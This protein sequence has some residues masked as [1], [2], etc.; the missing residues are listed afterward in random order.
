MVNKVGQRYFPSTGSTWASRGRSTKTIGSFVNLVVGVD[1]PQ[2]KYDPGTRNVGIR[3]EWV[4]NLTTWNGDY[5]LHSGEEIYGLDITGSIYTNG[6]LAVPP[7]VH[8][9]RI[10]GNAASANLPTP[11]IACGSSFNLRG[12]VF[13]WCDFDATGH[14]DP[15]LDGLSG[16]NFTVRH[17]EISRGVDGVHLTQGNVTVDRCRIYYGHYFA[18]WNDV[19][20]AVRTTSFTDYGGKT[21]NPPFPSQ[22]SGD[23]HTDGIQ[24]AGSGNNVIQGCY[25]G[26]DRGYAAASSQIDPTVAADYADMLT[27]DSEAGYRNAAI[28][29]NSLQSNPIGVTITNNWLHGGQARLNLSINGTDTAGGVTLTNNRFVRSTYGFYIYAQTGNTAT[30]SGN[31]YDDDSTPVSVVNW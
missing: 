19:A 5:L 7:Y 27:Y 13:E 10:R 31:V 12:T 21:W 1:K 9:C 16:G 20:G 23:T 26:G 8:D 30:M 6:A 4:N 15:F 17:C 11:A 18:W 2:G 29:L 24:V 25:V 28:I 22:S 14:E 3:P